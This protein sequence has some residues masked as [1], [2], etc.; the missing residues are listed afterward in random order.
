MD[1][2]LHFINEANSDIAVLILIVVEDG[3]VHSLVNYK[4]LVLNVLILIVVEDGLVLITV[5]SF[6]KRKADSLNPYYSG[7][8]T[9]TLLKQ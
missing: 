4:L 2:Y 9:R 5:E 3:L 1:S 8:W 7:R 6:P